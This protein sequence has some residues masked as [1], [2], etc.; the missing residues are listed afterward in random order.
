MG[1]PKAEAT[2]LTVTIA[3]LNATV[4]F[5]GLTPGF[6]D[7]HQINAVVPAGIAASSSVPVVLS[8]AGQTSP[9]VTIALSDA[10]AVQYND[11]RAFAGWQRYCPGTTLTKSRG[12]CR[13]AK[14]SS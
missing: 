5:A 3:G 1:P 2:G 7:L 12:A 4:N 9:P 6:P 14:H 8:V 13:T 10:P 11:T